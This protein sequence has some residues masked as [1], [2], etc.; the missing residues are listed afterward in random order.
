MSSAVADGPAPRPLPKKEAELFRTLVKFCETKQYKKGIK[1]ADTILKKIP[2]HGETQAMR[3]LCLLNIGEKAEAYDYIKRGIRNDIRSYICWHCYGLMHRQ[4][5]NYKEAVK[6]FLNALKIDVDNQQILRDLSWLQIQIRDLD[7]F[8]ET[9]RQLLHIRPT[10]RQFW[11]T[12][13]AANFLAGHYETGFNVVEK[14]NETVTERDSDYAESELLLFQNMCIEHQGNFAS[15]ITHLEVHKA[16]IVDKLGLKT[17][18]AEML[19]KDGR[20]EEARQ[21]WTG[22][23]AEQPD[24]YRF[25]TGLQTAYL[26]LSPEVSTEMYALKAL[27]LPSTTLDLS[28]EQ[29]AT[30]LEVHRHPKFKSR[31][32]VIIAVSLQDG[33]SFREAL[34]SLLRKNLTDTVPSLYA[35]VSALIRKSDTLKP[36]RKQLVSDTYEFRNHPITITVM[37]FLIVAY[38]TF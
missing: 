31:S 13:A 30:L 37:G 15:A 4:D 3:A 36:G 22:L 34:D 9:R 14:Y 6:C 26:E 24:N 20:F 8:V 1:S 16:T 11:V 17:K 28:P 32:A 10:A 33:L 12:Y 18:K 27:E 19:V 35:D 21:I 2:N 29:R 38:I 5:Q 7:G 23:V 25:L